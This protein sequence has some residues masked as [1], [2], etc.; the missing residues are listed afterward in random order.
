M[1]SIKVKNLNKS[2]DLKGLPVLKSFNFTF[3]KSK[4]YALMGPSGTGKS[5][6]LNILSGFDQQDSG[7]VQFGNSCEL[8]GRVKNVSCLKQ[9]QQPAGDLSLF[10][11]I[12][13]AT[14]LEDKREAYERTR[15]MI[16]LFSLHYKDE[17]YS[18]QLSFGQKQRLMLACAL[19]KKPSWLLLDEPFA[20]LD[21]MIRKDLICELDLIRKKMNFGMITV[22]HNIE[23][24]ISWVDDV[25][26]LNWGQI[27][28]TG[29]PVDLVE[30]PND[31]FTAR[32]FGEANLISCEILEKINEKFY[33][34]ESYF[35]VQ[36]I[37]SYH[38]LGER[39]KRALIFIRPYQVL[40]SP[41][42]VEGFYR[43]RVMNVRLSKQGN[44]ITLSYEGKKIIAMDSLR[45]YKSD[46][47]IYFSLPKVQLIS[48]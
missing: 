15:E 11:Q 16:D 24:V 10:D 42:E 22:T 25:I 31:I 19:A 2:Y 38:S 29:G 20:H 43:S 44:L 30:Y 32:Y 17:Y 28:Q 45:H 41:K 1:H 13:M 14:G 3:E 35:G 48:T 40:L 46:D 36:E 47:I 4:A 37:K 39:T 34:V 9:D 7:E 6:L 23:D 33:R 12:A 26:L 21:E 8:M 27:C 18:H 5:T